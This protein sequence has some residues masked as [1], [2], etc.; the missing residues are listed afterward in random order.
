[1]RFYLGVISPDDRCFCLPIVLCVLITLLFPS[2]V[3]CRRGIVYDKE[4]NLALDV[5]SPKRKSEKK[6]VLVFIHGGNWRNGKRSTYKFFGNGFAKKGI[7]TVVIDYRLSNTTT[8]VGMGQDVATSVKW[9]K[10]NIS[11][12]GGDPEKIFLSGHSSGGHLAALVALDPSYFQASGIEKPVKGVILIDAFGLDMLSYLTNS[13]NKKDSIYFPAFTKDT[14]S[15]RKGS[16]LY[17]IDK[18]SP[19][20]LLLTG[21]RTY[22]AIKNH[23]LQFWTALKIFQP[24]VRLVDLKGKKHMP[25]IAQFYN[26]SNK[27]YKMIKGFMRKKD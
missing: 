19:R 18:D 11:A 15:W 8:Y 22:P 2:C 12:Y 20:F 14:I 13:R 10:E 17:Y 6:E 25:M 27:L 5:Y 7:V 3:T 24:D 9:V 16:P 26:P 23:N 1:M 21:G 4:N